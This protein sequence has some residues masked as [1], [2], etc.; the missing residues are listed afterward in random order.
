MTPLVF[1]PRP[2]T[3]LTPVFLLLTSLSNAR[4]THPLFLLGAP[5]ALAYLYVLARSRTVVADDGITVS[6][7]RGAR[8][9]PWAEV[10]AIRNAGGGGVVAVTGDGERVVL[11]WVEW[12]AVLR[13]D[14]EYVY[15]GSGQAVVQWAAKAGHE[16]ALEEAPA[17][18]SR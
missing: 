16:V 12:R 13:H 6:T 18:H 4:V 11:P 2:S 14:S 17:P 10:A 7:W 9:L 1:R 5:L 8:L 3:W 15:A